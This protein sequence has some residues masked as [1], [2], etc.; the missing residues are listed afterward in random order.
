MSRSQKFMLSG[1]FALGGLYV[2]PSLSLSLP[3]CSCH[4]SATF[5]SIVRLVYLVRIS[6]YSSDLT[7]NLLDG[8]IWTNV[9]ANIA[10]VCGKQ[11]CHTRING[12][13]Q[14]TIIVVPA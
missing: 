10:F 1:I 6:G 5:V 8:L 4:H 2:C 12:Q 3:H 9:E 11:S 13:M 14:L 7:A